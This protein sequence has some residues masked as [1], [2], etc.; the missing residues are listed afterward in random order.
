MSKQNVPAK[1]ENHVGLQ[2]IEFIE[3]SGDHVMLDRLFT[4][5]G[6]SRL[7]RHKSRA[8]DYYNQ[9][10]IH[11][12]VNTDVGSHAVEFAKAHGPSV[13]A[14]GWRVKDAHAAVEAAVKRGATAKKGDYTTAD[15]KPVPA[16]EGIGGSLIYFIDH[17]DDA[18]RY[19][20]MGFVPHAKP[21]KVKEKG[22]LVIDH[23]T[24][25]V[26]EGTMKAWSDFYQNVFGFYEV[27]YFDIRGEK[28]GLGFGDGS[29]L[30]RRPQIWTI[31]KSSLRAPHSGQTQFM[32]TSAQSVP[33]AIPSS[34]APSVSS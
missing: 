30:R 10:D 32:G 31:S 26:E 20:R 8:V 17:W 34:G 33:A 25:N 29:R 1:I 2:G 4:E 6:F 9:N 24:N 19:E 16:I 18:K 11:F 3:Y 28:T 15:G 21:T 7:L 27:R 12:L 22:F 5:F 13:V 14:M 23:L